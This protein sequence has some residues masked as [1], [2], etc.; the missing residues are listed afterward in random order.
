MAN[1][2]DKLERL[3]SNKKK[4]APSR[5]TAESNMN[6]NMSSALGPHENILA[7]L[8]KAEGIPCFPQSPFIRP[9]ANMMQPRNELKISSPASIARTNSSRTNST[10]SQRLSQTMSV[11]TRSDEMN[12]PRR[13]S[14]HSATNSFHIPNRTSSLLSRRHDRIP[15]GLIQLH[16]PRE[17]AFA[18]DSTHSSL[19][20]DAKSF[21]LKEEGPL[22]G[23]QK[24]LLDALPIYPSSRVETPPPSDQ[25]DFTFPS[26]PERGRKPSA[27]LAQFQFTPEPSPDMIPQR[28]STLSEPKSN[29]ETKKE[30]VSA[31]P[32]RR[33]TT[34]SVPLLDD[35]WRD[36]YIQVPD[37]TV[38]S[39]SKT[40]FHEPAVED[41]LSMTDEDIAEIKVAHPSKPPSKR[42]PPPPILSPTLRSGSVSRSFAST[43]RSPAPVSPAVASSQVAAWEAARIAKKYD[44]DVVYVANFGPSRM[45]HLHNPPESAT[46][47][48]ALMPVS[49]FSSAPSSFSQSMPASLVSSPVSDK[50]T[51]ITRNST[52]R[53]SIQTPR[54][55]SPH[56]PPS[57]IF[58]SPATPTVTPARDCCPNAG[59]APSTGGFCGS[60]LA[61]YGL[62]TIQAPFRL[63][64]TVHKKILR[65][66]GWIEHRNSAAA[67]N[68]FARGY[69]LSFYT[70]SS[71]PSHSASQRRSS[72]PD[73]S[74][75]V[76]AATDAMCVAGG[77]KKPG[78]ARRKKINRG[79]VF[80][81]YRRPRGPDGAVNSSAAELNALEKEAAT[82]VDL[83]LDFH[84]DRR[85]WEAM[86]EMQD[87]RRASEGA[88]L[89]PS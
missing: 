55:A 7:Q 10:R 83:I 84:Q 87:A 28:N 45:N 69:A 22:K 32:S 11:G 19:F 68:E 59:L 41:F 54:I 46:C 85:R 25:D 78:G 56:N 33:G 9:K 39:K 79:I 77:K 31:P 62:E 82:L 29:T 13:Q 20:P 48:P 26:P 21:P 44:F 52:P 38:N 72:A 12:D 60:L 6:G 61:A 76:P 73:V 70:S 23:G 50:P 65:H 81:A 89:S 47:H 8:E 30:T 5:H 86:Q 35:D 67:D 80:V 1:G 51:T 43:L 49:G 15:G 63:S 40:V 36:S 18:G 64:S 16:L 37:D 3:F 42:A 57:D 88:A 2:L 75:R 4:P 71:M 58:A 53:N 24:V 34:S 74:R 14:T 27:K 17:T 66:E